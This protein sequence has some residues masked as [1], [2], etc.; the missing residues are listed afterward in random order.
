MNSHSRGLAAV[1]LLLVMV[2]GLTGLAG[3]HLWLQS[4]SAAPMIATPRTG[5]PPTSTDVCVTYRIPQA[6]CARAKALGYYCPRGTP[7]RARFLR[8]IV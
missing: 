1:P 8:F 4:H 6:S 3:W 5:M 2:I 7:N